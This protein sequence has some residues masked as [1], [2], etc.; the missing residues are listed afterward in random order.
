[1]STQ[2]NTELCRFV[3]EKSERKA[4][5]LVYDSQCP[6]CDF[7]C[8][9][10]HIRESIGELNLVD[11]RDNPKILQEITAKGWDIDEGMVLRVDNQL[12]YGSDAIHALSLLGTRSGFFNRLNYWVFKSGKRSQIL[13]P[14]LR[15]C[16]GFLLKLLRRTRINNL[17]INGRDRF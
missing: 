17:E 3:K 2:K 5:D 4:V 15:G 13:Y 1:M 16:R 14:F 8:N 11:A 9:L 7:Y 6:A 10:V 12:Y